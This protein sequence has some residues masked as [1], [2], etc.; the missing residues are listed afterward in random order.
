[1]TE[2]QDH[3]A[4]STKILR[5]NCK[6]EYQDERYGLGMRVFNPRKD[7]TYACTVCGRIHKE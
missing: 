7:K 2:N 6:N 4:K 3:T 1:M 5:C